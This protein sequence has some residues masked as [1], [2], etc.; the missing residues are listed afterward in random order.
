MINKIQFKVIILFFLGFL[1]FSFFILNCQIA[2]AD[3]TCGKDQLCNP[4]GNINTPQL[5]ISKVIQGV[6]G[7]VGSI[8]LIMFVY[9][10]FTWMMASGNQE[11]IRKG[12]DI[13]VWATIGLIVIFSAYAIT[14]FIFKGIG[15]Y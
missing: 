14:N 9:G 3:E 5:F 7:V 11:A 6:L 12:K 15:A 1:L 2:R 8:A 4:L 10:G 13:L